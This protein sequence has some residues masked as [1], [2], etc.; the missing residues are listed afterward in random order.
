MRPRPRI[1][2]PLGF[3][4]VPFIA[5]LIGTV[6]SGGVACS[7]ASGGAGW[8]AVDLSAF[9][10]FLAATAVVVLLWAFAPVQWADDEVYE[11]MRAREYA[12]EIR[13][14]EGSL[15]GVYAAVVGAGV[16][17]AAQAIRLLWGD[18]LKEAIELN[19]PL[20]N[21]S[22]GLALNGVTLG[23]VHLFGHDWTGVE[24]T[25][26]AALLALLGYTLWKGFRSLVR[27]SRPGG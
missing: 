5:T 8:G 21:G 25:L 16:L 14:G 15:L 22:S 27:A 20:P 11:R 1:R 10:G 7:Q 24:I 12:D 17:T 3:V 6:I 19:A 13:R 2:L 9:F 26:I 4:L 23:S 18:R